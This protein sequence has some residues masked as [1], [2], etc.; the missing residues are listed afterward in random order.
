MKEELR[1]QLKIASSLLRFPDEDLMASLD[2]IE[3]A[4]KA[5]PMEKPRL[6]FEDTLARMKEMALIEL[7][8]DYTR[9]F[10]LNP[11]TTL[12]LTYHRFGNEKKRGEALA[13]INSIYRDAGYEN[14][15]S[16]LPD[17]LPLILEFFSVAPKELRLAMMERVG[18]EIPLLA[19][20]LKETETVYRSLLEALGEIAHCLS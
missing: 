15:S 9:V 14:S 4:V 17:F 3:E 18:A 10:D 19:S 11:A 16:E 13:W 8:E 20:R 6:V 7:Q 1:L 5:L 12:N 2:F